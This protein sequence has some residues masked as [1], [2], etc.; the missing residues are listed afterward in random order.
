MD[1]TI[2]DYTSKMLPRLK[3]FEAEIIENYV[4]HTNKEEEPL[5]RSNMR[6]VVSRVPKNRAILNT[7]QCEP[8][9]FYDL[10]PIDGAVD[11]INKMREIGWNVFFCSHPEHTSE[12]CHNDK[13]RWVRKY[14]G[15]DAA[16]NLILTQD[17]TLVRGD[18]L[19]DD[20]SQIPGIAKPEWR[21]ILFTTE[22]NRNRKTDKPR[23]DSWSPGWE[24]A[25]EAVLSRNYGQSKCIN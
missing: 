19:I 21:H 17:K 10:E 9:F 14:F 11:A 12:Y 16:K 7:I 3:E 15:D 25:V 20:R 4:E 6:L 8:N 18:V 2:A 23:L 5:T 13:N 22:L 1:D 24:T